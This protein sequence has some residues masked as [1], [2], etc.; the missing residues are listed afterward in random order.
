MQKASKRQ[1]RYEINRQKYLLDNEQAHLAVILER[2]YGDDPRNVALIQF[3]L[4]TGARVTE[5]LNV[6]VCDLYD[7]DQTVH[8]RGIKGS[9]DRELPLSP[10]LFGA[11]KRLVSDSTG[12]APVFDISYSR[13]RQ[14]WDLYRPAN[15]KIHCLRHT[16]AINLYK[17]H[18]DLRLV[19][20][21]LGHRNINN[22]IVYAE[23]VYK[24]G[25]LKE[26]ML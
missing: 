4:N 3:L 22:T 19:Q 20:I 13:V 12:N 11:L 8:I 14:I 21:A 2:S 17:K 18:R 5:A 26:K 25:E 10:A 16:F 15:K 24:S 1:P 23:Y 9:S 6:R 7:E